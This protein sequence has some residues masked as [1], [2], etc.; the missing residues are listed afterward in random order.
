MVVYA[1]TTGRFVLMCNI[2]G[3]EVEVK[4]WA[5]VV[6]ISVGLD[7]TAPRLYFLWMA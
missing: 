2:E 4:S 5:G 6:Y 7:A 3:R 1:Y